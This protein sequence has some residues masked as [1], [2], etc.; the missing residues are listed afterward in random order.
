M[1]ALVEASLL[2][3]QYGAKRVKTLLFLSPLEGCVLKAALQKYVYF[4]G[5]ALPFGL[6]L[7]FQLLR[8]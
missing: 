3:G 5:L 4:N 8:Y 2:L 6:A 7:S 1:P